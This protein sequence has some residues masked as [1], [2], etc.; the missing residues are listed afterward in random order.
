[1][2]AN[3]ARCIEH[4]QAKGDNGWNERALQLLGRAL[5]VVDFWDHKGELSTE[6]E[7][8]IGHGQK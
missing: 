5:V 7:R 3:E 8:F 1:M 4:D 2:N 6:I